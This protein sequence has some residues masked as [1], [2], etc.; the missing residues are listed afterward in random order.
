MKTL[1]SF[2]RL[3]YKKLIKK[4]HVH[5]NIHAKADHLDLRPT[6]VQLSLEHDYDYDDLHCSNHGKMMRVIFV[7]VC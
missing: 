5:P 4:C 2:Q 6:K 3:H 1:K 7:V